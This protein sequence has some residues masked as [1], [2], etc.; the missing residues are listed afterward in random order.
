[1]KK[2][3]DSRITISLPGEHYKMLIELSE[4]KDVSMAWLIRQ[5]VN[6]YLANSKVSKEPVAE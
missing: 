3:C 6:D 4:I 5:A 1:M 2:K